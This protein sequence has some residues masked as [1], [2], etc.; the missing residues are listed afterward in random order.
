MADAPSP[1]VTPATTAPPAT[2]GV[3][4]ATVAMSQRDGPDRIS[5]TLRWFLPGSGV[6]AGTERCYRDPRARPRLAAAGRGLA[7]RVARWGCGRAGAGVTGG[8]LG[9]R[10]GGGWRYG[11]RAGAAAG[12]GAVRGQPHRG[13]GGGAADRRGPLGTDQRRIICRRGERKHTGCRCRGNRRWLGHRAGAG[14]RA[15]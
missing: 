10:P 8:A 11:W 1:P 6:T 2:P 4:P 14:P 15:G 7:L 5:A 13:P 12:R 9:L 3:G